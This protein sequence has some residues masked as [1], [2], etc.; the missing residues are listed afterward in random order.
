MTRWFVVAGLMITSASLAVAQPAAPLAPPDVAEL[1]RA[2]VATDD[3]R[4]TKLAEESSKKKFL[5]INFG[6][7]VAALIPLTEDTRITEAVLVPN[8]EGT[9][10]EERIVRAKKRNNYDARVLLETHYFFDGSP[11]F[12]YGPM[13]VLQPGAN[14]IIEGIGAGFLVGWRRSLEHSDS[15][16][17]GVALFLER[18][19]KGLGEGIKENRPLPAG[20]TEIRYE[21]KPRPALVALASFSF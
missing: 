9:P 18:S 14:E 5:G 19:V 12:G 3:V 13:V 6:I 11:R 15:F 8:A 10:A 1:Q 21:E 2:A 7:A 20:E 16:N 17:L 4:R